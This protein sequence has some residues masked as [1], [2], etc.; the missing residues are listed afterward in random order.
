MQ[1]IK[2]LKVCLGYAE[3]TSE[4]SSVVDRKP[5][6]DKSMDSLDIAVESVHELPSEIEEESL[7]YRSA[8]SLEGEGLEGGNGDEEGNRDEEGNGEQERNGD[9]EGSGPEEGTT[10]TN[11]EEL[12]QV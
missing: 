11:E 5:L 10:S 4:E 9:E 1:E 7:D 8:V 12:D 6:E 2:E 3:S